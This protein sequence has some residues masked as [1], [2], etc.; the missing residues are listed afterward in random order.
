[1]TCV[2]GCKCNSTIIDGHWVQKNSQ[3]LRP[4]LVS[5]PQSAVCSLLQACSK[6]VRSPLPCEPCCCTT[7]YA[8]VQLSMHRF[9]VSQAKECTLKI[10][11]LE[12]TSS[13][14]HKVRADS[15]PVSVS[16]TN[17]CLRLARQLSFSA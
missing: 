17:G 12:A 16:F 3:V 10:T 14:E 1:M 11:V 13:G 8:V 6:A 2:S 7:L 4:S 9:S 5:L 15:T